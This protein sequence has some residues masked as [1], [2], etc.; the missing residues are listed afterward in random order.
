MS[1]TPA[2][3]TASNTRRP[4]AGSK[5]KGFLDEDVFSSVGGGFGDI[6]VIHRQD[7]DDVDIWLGEKFFV[8]DVTAADPIPFADRIHHIFRDITEGA[9]LKLRQ[10][11]Q[12]GQM[13]DLGD[14]PAADDAYT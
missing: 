12:I 1:L 3:L 7:G 14:L 13:H 8:F 10:L 11:L 5:Q 6:S 4:S 2:R 9:N